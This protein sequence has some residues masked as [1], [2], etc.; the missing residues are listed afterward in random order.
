MVAVEN[1]DETRYGIFSF[2]D[3]EGLVPDDRVPSDV[4]DV[5]SEFIWMWRRYE[6]DPHWVPSVYMASDE[7]PGVDA[8]FT[9]DGSLMNVRKTDGGQIYCRAKLLKK[10]KKYFQAMSLDR[11]VIISVPTLAYGAGALAK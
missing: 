5:P 10:L 8:E 6:N 2:E 1:A 11:I 4:D 7:P 9:H 3:I